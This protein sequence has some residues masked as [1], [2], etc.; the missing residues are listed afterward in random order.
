MKTAFS[1]WQ[2]RIAP[3]FDV[4]RQVFILETK[5][6]VVSTRTEVSLPDEGAQGRAARLAEL[7]VKTLVC[8]AISRYLHGALEAAG[9][10]AI[11]FVSG[12]IEEVTAAWENG[13]IADA[14]FAMPGCCDNMRGRRRSVARV[15]QGDAGTEEL[16]GF[17]RQ[18]FSRGGLGGGRRGGQGNC[19]CPQ[20]GFVKAH[21]PG[22][23]CVSVLCPR[24]GI[25]LAR[26]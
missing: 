20:C 1:F 18:P 24:C 6:G 9:I 23:P 16:D 12:S 7:G 10:T 3:V 25:S 14:S 11:P 21:E 26:Q 4:S 2:G 13:R 8:G 5:D 17:G 22:T 19:V 15:V